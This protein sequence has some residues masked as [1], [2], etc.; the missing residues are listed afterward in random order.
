MSPCNR[1][2]FVLGGIFDRMAGMGAMGLASWQIHKQLG[3]S[4]SFNT[5][6]TVSL[7]IP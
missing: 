3:K 4:I 1:L 6:E 7:F 5:S 2:A